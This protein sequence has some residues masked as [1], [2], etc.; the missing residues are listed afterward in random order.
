MDQKN[1]SPLTLS[2]LVET[3]LESQ[4]ENLFYLNNLHDLVI[5]EAERA[6]IEL[7]LKKT[8][9]NQSKAAVM[10]GLNRNTL[11]KKMLAL[12]LLKDREKNAAKNKDKF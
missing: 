12:N 3:Y 5:Q 11:K 6:L 7:V 2:Q 8:R 4:K 9:Y 1:P 10:L